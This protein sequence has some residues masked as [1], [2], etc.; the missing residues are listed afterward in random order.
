MAV[1][2]HQWTAV[3]Y[4]LSSLV[5]WSGMALRAP[6]LERAAVGLLLLGAFLH[7][8][9]FSALHRLEPTPPL[10]N[11]STAV[12]F[13]AGV[14]TLFFLGLMRRLRL[15]GLTALVA[16]L[17]F[18]SV[19]F[20][21]L[22][23]PR[24]APASLA[25]TGTWPHAHVLLASAGLAFLA[26][27]GLAGALFLIEHRRLKAKRHIDVRLPLPS[28]EALDRVNRT[29][30]L[31]GF[32]LLTLGVV[33]GMMWAEAEK[34][35]FW[36]GTHHEL[37]CAIAWAVY[38]VLVVARFGASQG[39]RQAALSALGGFVFLFFAVVGVEILA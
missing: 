4:L 27:S 33:T 3:L 15:A 31:V 25:G 24:A 14:G 17:A 9:A 26:L 7:V 32:P 36:S 38:V 19:F 18:S 37:W 23:L 5:A 28:L 29:S 10:T 12:S 34:G 8:A 1:Q 20:A 35:V 2:L 13:T 11:L 21:A 6:R 22:R 16:P 30:L 39:R